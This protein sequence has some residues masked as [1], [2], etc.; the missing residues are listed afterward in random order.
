MDFFDQTSS[1]EG[2][3]LDEGDNEMGDYENNVVFPLRRASV[4]QNLSNVAVDRSLRCTETSDSE[5]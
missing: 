3:N 5:N 4:V 1:E 2:D